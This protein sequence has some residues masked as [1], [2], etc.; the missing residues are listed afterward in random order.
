MRIGLAV[1]LLAAIASGCAQDGGTDQVTP[2]GGQQPL[3]AP[4]A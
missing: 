3:D 4:R 1:L 2:A